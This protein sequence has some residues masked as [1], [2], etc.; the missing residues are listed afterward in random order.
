[1]RP[2]IIAVLLGFCFSCRGP[3]NE[4]TRDKHGHAFKMI[5]FTSR[6]AIATGQWL[7][8]TACYTT[9]SDSVF[10]DTA[11]NTAAGLLFRADSSSANHIVQHLSS[12]SVNDSGC[13]LVPQKNFF[14]CQFNSSDTPD[15]C[16]RDTTV[17]VF[18]RINNVFTEKEFAALQP[19]LQAKEDI[20]IAD[21][22]GDCPRDANGITWLKRAGSTEGSI[23]NGER[24]VG[25]SGR[26][27][28]GMVFDRR[29]GFAFRPG[30]PD[31]LI[32][33][34]NIVIPG[35]KKG[36]NAKII[37]PSRLAFGES[38]SSTGLVPPFTPV[39]YEVTQDCVETE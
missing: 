1:M 13:I 14:T 16:G 26:F 2:G 19:A 27:L 7:Q 31:Q 24:L 23:P 22:C 6:A 29:S 5:A 38:G 35:L 12:G 17:K 36:A 4:F 8:V 18:Y 39:L 3:S 20:L 9:L 30:T 33:G 21:F 10:W 25:Y 15:F 37:I 34:L 32:E 11:T 28:N